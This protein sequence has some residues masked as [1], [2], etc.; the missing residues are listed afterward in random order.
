MATA[1]FPNS[2]NN[3]NGAMPVWTAAGTPSN[4]AAYQ[5]V[6]GGT[7]ITAVTG[8]IFGG[9]VTNPPNAVSQGIATQENAYVSLVAAPGSTDAAGNNT[10]LVLVPGATF[11]LPAL[12]AGVNVYINAATTGHKFTV[13]TW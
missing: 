1:P 5:I 3:A 6:T 4:G 2:Q 9:F 12:G 10:T 7:A 8:P 13:V 11:N